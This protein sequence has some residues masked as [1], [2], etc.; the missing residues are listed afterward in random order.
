MQAFCN[1]DV[2]LSHTL[3]FSIIITDKGTDSVIDEMKANTRPST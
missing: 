3:N 1:G 2:R